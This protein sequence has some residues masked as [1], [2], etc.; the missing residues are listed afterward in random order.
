VGK[1]L[2]TT[3]IAGQP[4][5]SALQRAHCAEALGA[6][7]VRRDAVATPGD[8]QCMLY[9]AAFVRDQVASIG[10]D[11]VME[12]LPGKGL[13][14]CAMLSGRDDDRQMK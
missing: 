14:R 1:R 8:S 11:L 9:P 10:D 4:E 2:G 7:V 3:N 6:W 13:I 5:C 12:R